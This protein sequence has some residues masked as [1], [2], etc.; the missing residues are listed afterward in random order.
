LIAGA[1]DCGQ[2]VPAQP[3]SE[4]ELAD[5]AFLKAVHDVLMDLHVEEGALVCTHCGRKF[6]IKDGIPNMLLN[7]DEL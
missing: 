2:T 7:E 4:A 1:R 3:P 5:S 6:P